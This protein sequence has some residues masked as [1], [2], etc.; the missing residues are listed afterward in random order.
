MAK[1][2]R[3][4]SQSKYFAPIAEDLEQSQR[5][6]LKN[7]QNVEEK[8]IFSLNSNLCLVLYSKS[9]KSKFL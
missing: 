5:M 6:T 1:K 9:S 7:A 8:V 3:S 2:S 4:S